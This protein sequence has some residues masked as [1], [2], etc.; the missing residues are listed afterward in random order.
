MTFFIPT[1]QGLVE[2]ARLS[3]RAYLKGTDAYIWPNNMAV[4]A[5][6]MAGVGAEITMFAADIRK[7]MFALTA[8]GE[9][10]VMHGTQVGLAKRPAAPAGGP[11]ALTVPAAVSVDAGAVFA[12]A[13]GFRY[14]AVAAASQPGA[15]TL[16]I[17]AVAAADG[18]AG[19]AIAGTSLAIVSGVTGSASAAVGTGGIVAGDDIEEDGEPFT[20]DLGTFRGRILFKKANPPHGGA[21]SDYVM[22]G[23]QVSGVT[24]VYVERRWIGA[25]TVRVF[26]LMDDR[27]VDGIPSAADVQRVQDYIELV[28]PASSSVTVSAPIK[29]PIDIV[30]KDLSPNT[31]TM[32]QAILTELRAAF[33]RLSAVAGNDTEHDGMPYLASAQSFSREWIGQA[34][35]NTAG[36]KRHI[37]LQPSADTPLVSGEIATVGTV[38]FT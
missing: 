29:K 30:I 23:T 1:L 7:Q 28:A 10:L 34:I 31:V 11:I 2:R 37:L 14:L 27:Y 33:G 13:D 4:A 18:K 19:N 17:I 26:V 3:L 5:K 22:W 6:V 16:T 12:R 24:R 38:S 9:W 36:H 15:G 25:G 35:S 8:D 32:Q 20:S 21:P